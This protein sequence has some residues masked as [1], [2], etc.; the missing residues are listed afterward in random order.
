MIFAL[1]NIAYFSFTA[2][3]Y[4]QS[5]IGII[6]NTSHYLGNVH[7]QVDTVFDLNASALVDEVI[8]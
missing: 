2:E 6:S 8:M 1:L 4:I 7:K 3:S 5:L